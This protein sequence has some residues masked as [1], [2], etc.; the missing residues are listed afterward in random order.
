MQSV[1]VAY[2][3]IVASSPHFVPNQKAGRS[4]TGR[5]SSN[6]DWSYRVCGLADIPW[7]NEHTESLY[8]RFNSKRE[9]LGRRHTMSASLWLGTTYV[10]FRKFNNVKPALFRDS[11]A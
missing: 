8:R 3:Y 10:V 11:R 1:F 5:L 9:A 2:R 7:R 6:E 4:R